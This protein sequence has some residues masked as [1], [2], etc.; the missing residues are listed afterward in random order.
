M[1]AVSNLREAGLDQA[2]FSVG[3]CGRD[4]LARS[5]FHGVPVW[6]AIAVTD[7][8]GDQ[9]VLAGLPIDRTEANSID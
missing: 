8:C 5:G 7:F 1:I 4:R 3:R 9:A 2:G 6:P